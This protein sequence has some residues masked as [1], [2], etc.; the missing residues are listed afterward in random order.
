TIIA[1]VTAKPDTLR[2]P[3]TGDSA[4]SMASAALAVTLRGAGDSAA[5]GFL[6]KY[7]LVKA[8][9][10]KTGSSSPAVYLADDGGHLSTVD[11]SDASGASRKLVVNA[12]LLADQA[13]VAGQKTD[14]AVVTASASYRGAPV[15]GSPIRFVVPI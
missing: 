9:L 11:T 4:S 2:V 8:P 14:S 13:L 10:T 6:V 7:V 5:Q 1:A 12:T 15:S 3:I